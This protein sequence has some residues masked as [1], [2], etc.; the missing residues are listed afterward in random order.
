MKMPK[1]KQPIKKTGRARKEVQV[2]KLIQM[3]SET[4]SL[5]LTNYMGLTH[6]QMETLKKELRA[7]NSSFNVTKNS[8][9]KIA[10]EKSEFKNKISNIDEILQNPTEILLIKGDAMDSLKKL[11]KAMKDFGLPKVKVGVID[12]N[13]L[14]EESIIKLSTL[15]SK[16]I[17]I[18]QLAGMLN[19]PIA[20]FTFVLN[21]NLQK[22]VVVLNEVSKKKPAE[23]APAPTPEPPVEQPTKEAAPVEA[24]PEENQ[25]TPDEVQTEEKIGGGESTNG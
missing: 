23:A 1:I 6:K 14:D 8:L 20:R 7:V 3:L 2:S 5:V 13:F 17:L 15:P 12:G 18:I 19:S 10:L 16:E 24:K 11:A 25:T 22:L 4:K 21:A 9:F